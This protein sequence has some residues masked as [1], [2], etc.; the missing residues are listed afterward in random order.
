MFKNILCMLQ[1][2][3]FPSKNDVYQIVANTSDNG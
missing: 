3:D 2:I 1:E